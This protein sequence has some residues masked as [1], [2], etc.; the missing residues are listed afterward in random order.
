MDYY[1][2]EDMDPADCEVLF[3]SDEDE[4]EGEGSE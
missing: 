1:D 3:W 2:Y 4:D